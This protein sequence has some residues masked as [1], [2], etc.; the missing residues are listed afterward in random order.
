M[1]RS[2]I[3]LTVFLV[4]VI[5]V[6][7]LSAE[8][9]NKENVWRIRIHNSESAKTSMYSPVSLTL[10][11][12]KKSKFCPDGKCPEE[13]NYCIISYIGAIEGD[14]LGS[15]GF[16]DLEMDDFSIESRFK[17][18]GKIKYSKFVEL[19]THELPKKGMRS[20]KLHLLILSKSPTPSKEEI[21]GPFLYV[22]KDMYDLM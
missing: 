11:D 19:M 1:K 7:F 15:K 20:H 16:C 6:W 21:I 5:S 4:A 22:R 14:R 10:E 3:I 8:N 17:W 18:S 2:F 12:L 9:E 13:F